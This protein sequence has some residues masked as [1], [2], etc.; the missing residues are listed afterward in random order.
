MLKLQLGLSQKEIT[1]LFLSMDADQSGTLDLEELEEAIEEGAE[2][3]TMK[4][5]AIPIFRQ[6]GE[7]LIQKSCL[8]KCES[9]AT[10][11]GSEMLNFDGF[12]QLIRFGHPEMTLS[13]IMRLW[14]IVDKC[15]KGGI[16]FA[17]IPDLVAN[18]LSSTSTM[19]EATS[20][21]TA[22]TA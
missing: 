6:V 21:F 15:G 16:G 17:N 22:Y 8:E 10:P 2:A 7:S 20:G 9:L 18:I 14:C 11:L 3:D 5:V 1:Q 4:D 19:T 13:S 12:V